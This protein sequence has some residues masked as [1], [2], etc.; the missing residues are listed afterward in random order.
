MVEELIS[1]FE[2]EPMTFAE[3]KPYMDLQVSGIDG[4]VQMNALGIY[5]LAGIDFESCLA[6][7]VGYYRK[8]R[9]CFKKAGF[10]VAKFDNYVAIATENLIA[11]GLI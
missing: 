3:A 1:I 11:V 8:Y 2:N 6:K 4:L 10:S 7:E 5:S 9:D